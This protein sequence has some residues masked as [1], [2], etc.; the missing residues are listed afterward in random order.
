MGEVMKKFNVT[1]SLFCIPFGLAF[2]LGGFG[3][4][5]GSW[6]N[7]GPGLFPVVFGCLLML[8]SGGLLIHTLLSSKEV[9]RRTF[10]R[11][12][13]SWKAVL[14]AGVCLI[15][16]T[17]VLKQLGFLLT[18][19]LFVFTLMKFIFRKRWLVSVGIGLLLA[20]VSYALFSLL[21]GT[22]LPKG[23][24][25]GSFVRVIHRA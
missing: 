3:Y 16:Y 20:V 12:E 8:L 11:T 22:P 4:G 18:S 17:L 10:W 15:L 9:E 21:L 25:Y 1:S 24:I 5:F 13:G 2:V 7:P 19:F 14:L 23:Q 6:R